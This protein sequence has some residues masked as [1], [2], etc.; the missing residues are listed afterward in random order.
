VLI[1]RQVARVLGLPV[2]LPALQVRRTALS[3]GDR[4]VEYRC[5]TINTAHHDYVNRLS[6]PNLGAS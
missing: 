5:S 1:D 6:K 2:G 4:P 3:F